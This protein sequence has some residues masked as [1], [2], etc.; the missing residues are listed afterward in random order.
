MPWP[1]L[2][3]RERDSWYPLNKR[4]GGS[5]NWSGCF[6]EEENLVPLPGIG[7]QFLDVQP[8]TYL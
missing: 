2:P 3:P 5:R 1:V 6:G 4:E 7:F 8:M